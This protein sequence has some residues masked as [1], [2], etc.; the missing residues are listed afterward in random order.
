[1]TQSM[2]SSARLEPLERLNRARASL[3]Y[4]QRLVGL[5]NLYHP[6]EHLQ[7]DSRAHVKAF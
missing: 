3:D 1:M 5:V 2:A 6:I 4:L 7:R